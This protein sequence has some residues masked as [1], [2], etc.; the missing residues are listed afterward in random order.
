MRLRE[1]HRYRGALAGA[2]GLVIV[3]TA[4]GEAWVV[5]LAGVPVA[6]VVYGSLSGVPDPDVAVER[7]AD[8]ERPVPGDRVEVRLTVEN[9]SD[10]PLADVR[11]ADVP[12]E[13]LSVVEGAT[14]AA[15]GI[16]P[17]ETET[18][19]YELL[20]K[21][22]EHEFGEPQIRVRGAAGGSYRDF[23][24][25]V[26]GVERIAGRVF[27]EE[28]PTRRETA[29]LV[30]AVPTD[31]G[32]SGIEFHTTREYR[33]GDPV[34]RIDWRRL[35]RGG[36][37]STVDF[38]EHRGV[39]VVVLA[40]CRSA[41]DRAPEPGAPSGVD[42]CRYAADRTLHAFVDEGQDVGAAALGQGG[43]PWVEPGRSDVLARARAALRSV[44]GDPWGG[45]ELG[46]G[47]AVGADELVDRLA[48]RLPT[49]GQLVFVTPLLDDLP[50]ELGRALVVR[51]HPVTVLS[52]DMGEPTAPGARLHAAERRSR[53]DLLREVGVR[54]V[55][56]PRSDPLPIA[57][58]AAEV[59]G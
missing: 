31:T 12:P 33:P 25:A 34:N 8:P 41:V 37:L 3:G 54:V 47:G 27:V 2:L 40:D 49:N 48:P 32:G 43:T 57:V 9:R 10:R 50:I 55:D 11:I 39:A 4:L 15:V 23:A 22:G 5:A 21:R 51:G 26:G 28:P 59:T 53:I 45:P 17:G 46:I 58:E 7:E 14:G 16:G 24:P 30:G 20:A 38:R 19:R 13:E 6:F 52:P 42:L 36:G 56:W 44:D 35:A 1:V 29:T 18:V